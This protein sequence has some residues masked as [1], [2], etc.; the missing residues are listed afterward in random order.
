MIAI[1]RCLYSEKLLK[2]ARSVYDLKLRIISNNLYGVD[3]D[4]F[5]TNIARLRLW[6]SLAVEA[7]NPLPLPNLDFKIETGDSLLAPDPSGRG[8]TDAFRQKQ[9]ENFDTL[10][11]RYLAARRKPDKEA[12]RSKIAN[13]RTEIIQYAHPSATVKGFDWRVEFAEVWQQQEGGFDLVLANPPYVN[14]FT[15]DSNASEYRD[16]LKAKFKTARKGFDLFVPFMERGVQLLCPGGMFVYI[17][18]NKLL[19]AEYGFDLREYM[20][21]RMHIIAL[22][23]LSSI[24]VF[25]AAV[26]PF[27]TIAQKRVAQEAD[28]DVSIFSAE[29]ISVDVVTLKRVH[30]V[31]MAITKYSN[32]SWSPLVHPDVMRLRTVLKV[33]TLLRD[34]A[35]I[36]AS[37][38]VDEAYKWQP[39]IT[40][41]GAKL[42]HSKPDRFAPFIVSGNVRPYFHTWE[43]EKVQYLKRR[44]QHPV[45]DVRHA[46]ITSRRLSQIRSAKVVVSG[47]SKRP[48]CVWVPGPMATGVATI[49]LIPKK[50]VKGAFLAG[51]INSST[52]EQLYQ[53]L[54]GS[55]SLAGGYL[56]FG[57]PQLSVLPL[58]T[59]SAEEQAKIE[60][61]VVKCAA[62]RGAGCEKWEKEID[63]RVAALYG[64]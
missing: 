4:P 5:A 33:K 26:Y 45:L 24:P 50:G 23:D 10:K 37:A 27:I 35:D 28:P 22:S 17:T 25:G 13:L 36:S 48:T 46:S 52:M 56:R 49:L 11:T 14:M 29:A 31:P 2:D 32:H 40:D 63:E 55:L 41:Y 3:I 30:Q 15:M 51:V 1:Y 59:S 57:V 43:D 38:T 62:A 34:F 58:P 9:I 42:L 19:S 12:L 53:L 44:F 20:E 8:Q 7:E 21:Q 64:L 16:Q 61:L 6:L 54:F 18:P 60:S 47:M 39:A